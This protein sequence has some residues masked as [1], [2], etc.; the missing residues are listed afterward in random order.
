MIDCQFRVVIQNDSLR[1]RQVLTEAG[2]AAFSPEQHCGLDLI[3]VVTVSF[4]H[5]TPVHG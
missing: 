2:D 5:V 1:D 3:Q 4:F